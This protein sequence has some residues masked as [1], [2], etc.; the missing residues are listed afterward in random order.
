MANFQITDQGGEFG[1]LFGGE[2]MPVYAL[3]DAS[4][5]HNAALNIIEAHLRTT[6][7]KGRIVPCKQGYCF[8]LARRLYEAFLWEFLG[9]AKIW[10][11]DYVIDQSL[12]AQWIAAQLRNKPDTDGGVNLGIE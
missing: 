2:L 1:V 10:R 6:G 8:A 3:V 7:Y 5:T 12:I 4:G 9:D 11:G